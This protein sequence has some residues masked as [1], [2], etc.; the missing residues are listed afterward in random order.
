[1]IQSQRITLRHVT[2]ADLPILERSACDP[3]ARGEHTSIRM[4]SPQRVRARFAEDGFSSEDHER[5]LICDESGS[6]I[7]DV[8]H[9]KAKR[10]SDTREVG[11][12]I[13]DPAK[14]GQGYASEAVNALIDYLFRALPINRVEC[15]TAPDNLPSLR[16]AEKCGF[17]RE[18][19]LRG[20]MFANGA[21]I[22]SVVLS[23]LRSEWAERRAQRANAVG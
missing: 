14:R 22:D 18:G 4:V 11:W 8:V 15:N 21:Y 16:M 7:G 6:V 9:F 2:E 5:L 12:S 13:F 23:V 17:V 20:Y 10:Y 1:M 3:V 19:V